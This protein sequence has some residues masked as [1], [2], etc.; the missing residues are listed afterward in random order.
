VLKIKPT[1]YKFIYYFLWILGLAALQSTLLNHVR[2]FG[3]SP[4]LPVIFV[5]C[6]AILSGSPVESAI[7]GFVSGFLFDFMTGHS[8]GVSMLLLMYAGVLNGL[9]FKRILTRKYFGI[10]ATIFIT[11]FA[12]YF[13]YYSMTFL[14]WGQGNLLY[15][16]TR[17]IIVG[18]VYNTIICVPIYSLAKRRY[19]QNV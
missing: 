2:I 11:S 18:T 6:V 14:I 16:L 10:L 1:Y 5:V 4:N 7:V 13:L 17:V 15:A 12:F 19:R 3:V 8:V 9:I